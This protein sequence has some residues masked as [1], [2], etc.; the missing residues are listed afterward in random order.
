MNKLFFFLGFYL[1]KNKIIKKFI[2]HNANLFKIKKRKTKN[3]ILV[4][5]NGWSLQ[6][7][8]MSYITNVLALKYSANIYAYPGYVLN[9]Y[10]LDWK[11]KIKFCLANL[12]PIKQFLIYVSFG[13]KKFF[14]PKINNYENNIALKIYKK[15]LNI[16]K[17]LEDICR[18][19]INGVHVG[20]LIYDSYL[21]FYKIPTIDINDQKFKDF[22]FESIKCFVFWEKYLS[23]NPVKAIVITHA[24]YS[25]AMPSRIASYKYPQIKIISGN[26]NG[27]Y[28]FSKIEQNPWLNFRN[29]RKEFSKLSNIEK[30]EGLKL[31]KKMIEKRLRGVDNFD[32]NSAKKSPYNLEYYKNRVIKKSSN[33][34]IIVAAHCFLDSPHIFGNFFFSDFMQWLN[35]LAKISEKTNYDWYIKS[36]PNFNPLTYNFL[37]EFVKQNKKFTLLPLNYG[38]KQIFKE[39]I[40]FAL[41]VYGTIGWE[42]A[43]KDIPVIN[44]SKNNPHFN[45]NFNINPRSIFEYKR[46]LL[47]L[48]KTKIRINKSHIVEYYFIA[49][50]YHVV[51]WLFR[52]QQLLKNALK[53][54]D[55]SFKEQT[56]TKWMNNFSKIKHSKIINGLNSFFKSK[57]YKIIQKQCEYSLIADIINKKQFVPK[58]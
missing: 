35:F 13:T 24:V 18:I 51:D 2:I 39:K 48:K 53:N 12:I 9:K 40:D 58:T 17:K 44:A 20:D 11:S 5:F 21:K 10:T 41:T 23:R 45:Y 55:R 6:H 7:I 52:D 27:V 16:L 38:H 37:K 29:L 30:K 50:I 3:L 54:F 8:I 4:E 1:T 26:S 57:N 31:S 36:H 56:Y 49:Y 28:S 47:N 34:K 14:Y 33:I 43:Y 25:G 19:K 32:L 15:K 42:Y 46:I 22:L